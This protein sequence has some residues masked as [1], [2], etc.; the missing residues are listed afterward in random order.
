MIIVMRVIEYV[1]VIPIPQLGTLCSVIPYNCAIKH[2][3]KGMQT[4]VKLSYK[5]I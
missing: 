1:M 2:A 5:W 3:I 4:N